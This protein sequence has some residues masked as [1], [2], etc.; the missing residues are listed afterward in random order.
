MGDQQ[1]IKVMY[2]GPRPAGRSHAAFRDRWREHGRLAMGLPMWRHM[3]RYEQFDVLCEGEE[4]LTADH[5]AGTDT[6][7]FGGVGMI[8]FR[9]AHALAS[10]SADPDV[11]VMCADEVKTFGAELGTRLVPTVENFVVDRGPGAITM[12]GTVWRRPE[13]TREQFSEQW[14]A[15]GAKF[16][17][18]P[19]LAGHVSRYVQNHAVDGAGG[20]DGLVQLEFESVADIGAFMAEPLLTE[21]LLPAESAFHVLERLETVIAIRNVLYDE[22]TSAVADTLRPARSPS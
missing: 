6:D 4:G 3:T 5:L 20:C 14:R 17:E 22:L 13:L 10:A 9:D 1:Q 21:W 2:F 18:Q 16:G 15:L 7:A 19:E 8:W 11:A 12:L